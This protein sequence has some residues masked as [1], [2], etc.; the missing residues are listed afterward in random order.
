MDVEAIKA[1]IALLLTSMQN[2]PLDET[3]AALQLHEKLREL[4]A[5]GM[6]LPQDLVDLERALDSE[7]E[8]RRL[9]QK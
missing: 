5:Y 8:R 7:L 1:E 2:E 4:R 3:E 6:P 9:A